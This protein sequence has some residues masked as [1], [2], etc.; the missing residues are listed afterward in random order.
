MKQVDRDWVTEATTPA[1]PPTTADR[2]SLEAP[3]GTEQ[4]KNRTGKPCIV[5]NFKSHRLEADG[6]AF[7]SVK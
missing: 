4:G 1:E 7:F 2:L 5:E 6:R 3:H